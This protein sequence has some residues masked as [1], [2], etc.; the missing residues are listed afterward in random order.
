MN[1]HDFEEL[2]VVN[3]FID[4]EFDYFAEASSW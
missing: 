4:R 2:G 1:M 3:L